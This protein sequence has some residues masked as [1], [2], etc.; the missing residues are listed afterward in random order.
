MSKKEFSEEFGIECDISL[1]YLLQKEILKN[2]NVKFM[3]VA[4]KH[5]LDPRVYVSIVVEGEEPKKVIH[6]GVVAAKR[7]I[8]DILTKLEKA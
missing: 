8:T 1:L 3:G 5:P 4:K 6:E 7:T 2:K